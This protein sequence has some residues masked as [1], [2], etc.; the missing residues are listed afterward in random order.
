MTE[1]VTNSSSLLWDILSKTLPTTSLRLGYFFAQEPSSNIN[2]TEASL[3]P[4]LI[5][6]S[7][8]I[9]K[10][11]FLFE[12]L[13]LTWDFKIYKDLLLALTVFLVGS[14][15][16]RVKFRLSFPLSKT[17]VNTEQSLLY[18]QGLAHVPLP[19]VSFFKTPAAGMTSLVVDTISGHRQTPDTRLQWTGSVTATVLAR[20]HVMFDTA[21]RL[22]QATTGFVTSRTVNIQ[23]EQEL[24]TCSHCSLSLS[25]Y[26]VN[27]SRGT[28]LLVKKEFEFEKLENF[29]VT[30]WFSLKTSRRHLFH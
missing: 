11:L 2:S 17:P 3:L 6:F 26:N 19:L 13:W 16:L 10:S 18:G 7:M 9:L 28:K 21:G 23:S 1:S 24:T 4:L 8:H 25:L 14:H 30:G 29:A 12:C 5:P 22:Q 27:C 20:V 15:N